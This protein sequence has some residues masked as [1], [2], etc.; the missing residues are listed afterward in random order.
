MQLKKVKLCPQVQTNPG[1][2]KQLSLASL[3]RSGIKTSTK[4]DDSSAV[5]Q[6]FPSSQS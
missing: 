3:P 1:N 6:Q 5:T 2:T 4:A